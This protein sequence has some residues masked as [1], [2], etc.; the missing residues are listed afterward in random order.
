MVISLAVILGMDWMSNHGAQIDCE[1]HTVSIRRPDG[2]RIVYQED[3]QSQL[4]AEIH[5]NVLTEA[6]I[7][8]IPVVH[9]Y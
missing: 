4:Q 2:G 9:E 5:L 8:D 3:K 7:E 1:R 6:T